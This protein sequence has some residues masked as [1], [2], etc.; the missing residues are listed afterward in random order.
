MLQS[1]ATGLAE[2]GLNSAGIIGLGTTPTNDFI[3]I[4]V[5]VVF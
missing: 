1:S 5:V 4:V 3:F 2:E